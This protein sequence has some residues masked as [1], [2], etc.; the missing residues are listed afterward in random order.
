MTD[1]NDR[2]IREFPEIDGGIV[3]PDDDGAAVLVT[4]PTDKR[5]LTARVELDEHSAIVRGLASYIAGLESAIAGRH[6]AMT[7]VVTHWADHDDG[8]VPAPSCVVQ[9]IELGK[10]Q[11]DTGLSK[12][13]VRQ[14]G[15]DG[16]GKIA[17][18]RCDSM[19]RLEELMVSVR[20][21]DKVQRAGV[22]MM[23]RQAFAPVE[24]MPGFRLVLPLYHNAVAEY[25]LVAA[26]QA[27]DSAQ[28]QAS[29][30]P[31]VLQLHARCPVYTAHALPL[32]RPIARGT[33][34]LG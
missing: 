12:G 17:A 25:L 10:Y 30:W 14:I 27:D 16:H 33:I 5:D 8:A 24:W 21:A 1:C 4:S 23:L 29:V 18:L 6:I 34:G 9:S 32:A 19:Y 22:R 3:T 7:R 26:Q 2:E 11:T 31:L 13:P 20:C 28:A 15:A